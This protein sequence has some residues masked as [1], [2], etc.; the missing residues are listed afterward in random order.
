MKI[1]NKNRHEV[2][3]KIYELGLKGNTP[4]QVSE[5]LQVSDWL[6]RKIFKEKSLPLEGSGGK[7]RKIKCNFLKENSDKNHYF[8]GYITSDGNISMKSGISISSIDVEYLESF[9]EIYKQDFS[10]YYSKTQ[11]NKDAVRLHFGN[12][13]ITSFLKDTYGLE[14]NKSLTLELKI[15]NWSILRGIFDGDGSC[16]KEIKITTGSL[17]FKNQL[18]LF[19]NQYNI[20]AKYRIKGPNKNCYD[21]V[22]PAKHH[23][24]FAFY[25]Y[26]DA[27]IKM[28]RKYTD[29][30]CLL[31]KD[32]MEKWDKLLETCNG[33][34]QLSLGSV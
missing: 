11:S 34:Q 30:C 15:L 21:V 23:Y 1:T 26:K 32:N 6:T 18:I 20:K 29:M 5:I 17:K 27:T 9:K 10:Y 22:I 2:H 8:I 16:K 13:S 24:L 28:S 7:N 25:L 12:Q 33:N 31:S 4:I 14:A 3:N 19:L